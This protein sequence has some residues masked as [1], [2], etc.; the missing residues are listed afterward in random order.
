M[1]CDSLFAFSF[2]PNNTDSGAGPP[3]RQ[4]PVVTQ[5]ERPLAPRTEQRGQAAHLPEVIRCQGR[6]REELFRRAN[7]LQTAEQFHGG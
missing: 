3:S 5:Q 7:E 2:L 6:L 4:Q 1:I